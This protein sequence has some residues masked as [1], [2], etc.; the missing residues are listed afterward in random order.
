MLVTTGQQLLIVPFPLVSATIVSSSQSH[1]V[2]CAPSSSSTCYHGY[3]HHHPHHLLPLSHHQHHPLPSRANEEQGSCCWHLPPGPEA[4]GESPHECQRDE[5]AGMHSLRRWHHLYLDHRHRSRYGTTTVSHT[6]HTTWED[7]W[8]NITWKRK[9]DR[10][11]TIWLIQIWHNETELSELFE[12]KKKSE[13]RSR[14]NEELEESD[15]QNNVV[16]ISPVNSVLVACVSLC[17]S[18]KEL[19]L[20]KQGYSLKLAKYR[21]I[22]LI[23]KILIF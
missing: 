9:T 2:Q 1:P 6:H 3:K 16:G 12:W 5:E 4:R 7:E 20:E 18:A 22:V 19:L 15:L 8:K 17:L 23:F 13:Y 11:D 10:T 14:V 21:I